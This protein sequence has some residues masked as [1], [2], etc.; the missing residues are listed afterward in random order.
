MVPSTSSP[1]STRDLLYAKD[2]P[3]SSG[4]PTGY[5]YTNVGSIRNTGFELSLDGV[6]LRTKN[7][8][9][10]ANANFTSYKNKILSLD[11]SVA[12]SGIKGSYYIRE[13]GG[14]LYDG[15]MYKYAGVDAETGKALYYYDYEDESGN[16]VTGTTS[17]FSDATKYKIGSF[18]PKLYGGFGTSV[19]A[20]GFDFSIQC[21]YQLGGRYYDGQ[22]QALMLSQTMLDRIFTKIFSMLGL[23]QHQHQRSSFGW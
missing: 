17:V 14:S 7:V 19:N 13:V 4:N 1:V 3:Y 23:Y 10:T 22:Y 20:Y 6:I 18:L 11:K 2:V 15:Y 12:E 21:S 8:M 9:W 16:T 5:I